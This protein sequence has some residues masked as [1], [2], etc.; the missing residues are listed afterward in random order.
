M[1]PDPTRQAQL[2]VCQNAHDVEDARILLD[3]LGLVEDTVRFPS[4]PTTATGQRAAPV[5]GSSASLPPSG[6]GAGITA[7]PA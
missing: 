3:M 7:P 2:S 5:A 1:Q 6:Y 4:V